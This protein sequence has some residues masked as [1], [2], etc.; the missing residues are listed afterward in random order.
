M[1]FN[2]NFLLFY[3][4]DIISYRYCILTGSMMQV[5]VEPVYKI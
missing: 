2:L 1:K 5:Q 4:E 3:S